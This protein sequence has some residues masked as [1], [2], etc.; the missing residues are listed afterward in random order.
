[1]MWC[2]HRAIA[3]NTIKSRQQRLREAR[4]TN[5]NSGPQRMNNDDIDT[6]LFK[7]ENGAKLSKT[8]VQRFRML[9]GREQDGLE[10]EGDC[11][12]IEFDTDLNP[13]NES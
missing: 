13:N 9:I 2:V 10:R 12:Y 6:M 11:E 4:G 5:N 1:M 3:K 8:E 7:M